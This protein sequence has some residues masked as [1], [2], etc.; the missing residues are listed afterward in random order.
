MSI[1]KT[2]IKR[3]KHP[4]PI[5]S[6]KPNGVYAVFHILP[7]ELVPEW[8]VTSIEQW[9]IVQLDAEKNV[10][11]SWNLTAPQ[12]WT[13]DK[14][15]ITTLKVFYATRGEQ[16]YAIIS[17]LAIRYNSLYDSERQRNILLE[18]RLRH[19]EESRTHKIAEAIR[20]FFS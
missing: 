12:M 7:V 8:N 11:R 14:V 1:F 19:Y 6:L 4:L 3:G 15:D 18:H 10:R 5:N 16:D 20:N 13:T 2:V 9:G 17:E